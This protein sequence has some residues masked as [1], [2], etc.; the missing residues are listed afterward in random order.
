MSDVIHRTTLEFRSS[1]NEPDY[2]E[3]TWKW[4]PDMSQVVGVDSRYWKWDGT[5]ERPIPMTGP[6]QAAVDAAIAAAEVTHQMTELTDLVNAHIRAARVRINTLRQDV[7]DLHAEV[8]GAN[9][10]GNFKSGVSG[11]TSPT[12]ITPTANR[13]FIQGKLE[14]IQGGVA[15]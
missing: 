12:Q 4:N 5:N 2:P 6:E 10:Y 8:A 1:V 7:A 14:D 9:S 11:L 13:T 3:P 15:E